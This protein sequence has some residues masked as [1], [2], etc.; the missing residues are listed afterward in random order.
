MTK[1]WVLSFW[2]KPKFLNAVAA[3][4]LLATLILMGVA[5]TSWI[6]RH[7]GFEI[8]EIIVTGMRGD[9]DLSHQTVAVIKK[10]VVPRL[11]GNFFTSDLTVIQHGFSVLPWFRHAE[12]RR[13]WPNRIWVAL[14][15]HQ[16]VAKLNDDL[17]IDAHG[18]PFLGVSDDRW[19]KLPQFYGDKDDIALMQARFNHLNE[20]LVP[21]QVTV[22]QLSFSERRAWTAVLSNNVVLDIG[23]DDL[24][25]SVEQRM[26]RWVNTWATTQKSANFPTSTRIDLRYPNGYAV[27]LGVL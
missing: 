18:E 22:K 11:A 8:K 4:M 17:L 15:E 24:Q 20:W 13:V 10:M 19:Q 25:P 5:A 3:L 1:V 16:A 21:M 9:V 6:K 7:P 27:S 26:L 14:E 23:R 2:Y 12:V